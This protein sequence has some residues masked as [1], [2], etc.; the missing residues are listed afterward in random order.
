MS[1]KQKYYLK[2]KLVGVVSLI[3]AVVCSLWIESIV[4]AVILVPY[5]LLALFTKEMMITDDYYL[6]VEE[7]KEFRRN[8]RKAYR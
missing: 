1:R 3:A 5:G 7:E 6:E 4:P 8:M 2:Q